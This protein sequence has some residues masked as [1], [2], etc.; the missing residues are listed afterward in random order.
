MFNPGVLSWRFTVVFCRTTI[1][2]NTGSCWDSD[3]KKTAY[4]ANGHSMKTFE[5]EAL[6][7]LWINALKWL[8][9]R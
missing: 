3:G 4:L 7:P 5:C 1:G 6:R 2:R 8:L 9:E